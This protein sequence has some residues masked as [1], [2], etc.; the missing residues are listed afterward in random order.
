MNA[1]QE[2]DFSSHRSGLREERS[3]LPVLLAGLATTALTLLGVYL[4]DTKADDFNIMGLYANYVIP[5]GAIIVGLAA[6]SGYGL[7]S[8]F[9]GVRITRYLLWIVV[10]LQ[11]AA[12]FAAQYIEFANLH[13]VHRATG[14]PVG[15]F[16]YYDAAARTFAWRQHDGT[17]GQ[18]LGAWGYF[19][20]GL[21]VLGF[22]LGGLIVPLVLRKAPYCP[23]CQLYMKTRQL[24]LVPASVP[25]R[26]VKKSDEAGKAAYEAE[27]QKAF[28]GGK[29]TVEAIQQ[30]AAGNNTAEFRTKVDALQLEKKQ[31]GKLPSRFSLSLIHCKRCYGGRLVTKLLIGQGKQMK[32]TDFASADL[33]SEFVRSVVQ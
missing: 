20:R 27:Q 18:P 6:A 12:Y 1:P 23:D 3:Y 30:F 2:N 33:H 22:V 11:F 31:A 14:E 9:T 24:G 17:M 8:W 15:F 5:A 10:L 21:E 19:F 13:L 25:A 29:Q 4:L 32:R 7:T 26:K 16:E 28:D